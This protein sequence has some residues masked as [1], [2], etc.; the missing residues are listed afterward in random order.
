[1]NPNCLYAKPGDWTQVAVVQGEAANH[2]TNDTGRWQKIFGLSNIISYQSTRNSYDPGLSKMQVNFWNLYSE[3]APKLNIS[4]F[5]F[6][7]CC[8]HI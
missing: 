8:D 7:I 2:Y 6:E 5:I 3:S 4:R 1:M